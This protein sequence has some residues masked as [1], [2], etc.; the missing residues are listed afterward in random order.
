M[1]KIGILV[2]STDRGMCGGLNVNLFK[3]TL[4]QIKNW[5]EQNI[6][7]DLGLI[8]SKGISFFRSF[9]FNIKG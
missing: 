9:G 4:N 8:G 7:T 3:T 6:S 2:I 5:K 1:K